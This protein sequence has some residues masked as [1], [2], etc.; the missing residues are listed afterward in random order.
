MNDA[1]LQVRTPPLSHLTDADAL[2]RAFFEGRKERTTQA[3]RA[4][5][6]DFSRFI[7]ART[8]ESAASSLLADSAA[9]ANLTILGYR[10]DL[11]QRHLSAA[12]VNRR[13]SAIR[14][15]LKLAKSLGFVSWEVVAKNAPV[16]PYRDT[17]G[18]TL[19]NVRRL[20]AVVRKR[21]DRKGIRD[22]ALLRLMYDLALRRN[23]AVTLDLSHAEIERGVLQVIRKGRT[24][25]QPMTLAPPTSEALKLWISLRGPESGPLFL[26]CDRAGKGERLTGV[27]VN[28]IV[29][30]W[31]TKIGLRLTAHQLR[32]A[33]ITHA[34]DAT[35]G[36]VRAVAR[37]SGHR[38]LQTLVVYDDNRVDLGA[39][40]SRIIA[41]SADPA[42]SI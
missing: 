16:I 41:S 3:Y 4:D 36:D 34:L 23:E 14:S 22:F 40:I 31:G 29:A 35:N 12:T 8:T 10:A 17:K 24:D 7:A 30:K 15:L 21:P 42:M 1:S 33:A 6:A 26:N 2:V 25:R 20:F 37:F 39:E 32:H 5:L 38:Q 9:H 13:L 18:P 11:L 28:R 19:Q 27:S